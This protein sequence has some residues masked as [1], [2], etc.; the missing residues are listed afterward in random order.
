MSMTR[1]TFPSELFEKIAL[2]CDTI[3]KK[4]LVFTCKLFYQT[5]PNKDTVIPVELLGIAS[6]QQFRSLIACGIRL[7]R[8]VC[9]TC[10]DSNNLESFKWLIANGYNI[11]T[12]YSKSVN[13][14]WCCCLTCGAMS[15]NSFD[16][17]KRSDWHFYDC[18]FVTAPIKHYTLNELILSGPYR[19]VSG[20]EFDQ[21]LSE[22]NLIYNNIKMLQPTQ[23][24]VIN[25]KDCKNSFLLNPNRI[26]WKQKK[27]INPKDCKYSFLLNPNRIAWNQKK[28]KL[29]STSCHTD[30]NKSLNVTKRCKHNH[31][32]RKITQP[33]KH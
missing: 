19:H 15:T 26:Q 24:K 17:Y 31:N 5:I 16:K 32:K 28:V 18:G 13:D 6:K 25:S 20:C 11:H 29:R 10:Y 7:P 12:V 2:H 14:A 23:K 1:I 4:V 22:C 3:T 21:W 8:S 9:V 30:K 27:V 33:R